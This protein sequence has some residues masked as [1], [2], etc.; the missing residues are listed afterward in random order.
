VDLIFSNPATGARN[1]LRDSGATDQRGNRA[2][3]AHQC[4]KLT[5]DAWNF[6]SVPL[7]AV[8]NGKKIVQLD[9]GYDQP[10]NTGGYR[11]FIDD[12]RITR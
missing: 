4:G 10:A 7:G 11:G 2:H 3:P 1:S 12:I 6:V 9:L 8:A 5:L